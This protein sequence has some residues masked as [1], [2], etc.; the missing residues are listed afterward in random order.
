MRIAV[1]SLSTGT[2]VTFEITTCGAFQYLAFLT[3]TMRLFGSQSL[4]VYGPLLTMLPGR[5]QLSPNL[6]TVALFT[7]AMAGM[8]VSSVKK[9]TGTSVLTSSVYGS[10][11]RAASDVSG[12]LPAR[13]A[14]AFLMNSGRIVYFEPVFGSSTRCHA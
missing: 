3:I 13:I 4:S 8:A 7:G 9:A 1:S 14:F 5:V 11:T 10:T 12:A 2:Y 6:S